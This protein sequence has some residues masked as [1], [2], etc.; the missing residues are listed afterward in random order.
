M[1]PACSDNVDHCVAYSDACSNWCEGTE[2]SDCLNKGASLAQ[3]QDQ[4]ACFDATM[5]LACDSFDE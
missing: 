2:L 1:V 5:R 3:D 4:E